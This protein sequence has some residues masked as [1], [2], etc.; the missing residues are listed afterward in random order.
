VK[1]NNEIEETS[2][3]S[4]VRRA[5]CE[6]PDAEKIINKDG[7]YTDQHIFQIVDADPNLDRSMQFAE[8]WIKH[9]ASTIRI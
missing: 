3:V 1:K 8:M 6:H 7:G 4:N 9:C 5:A 2:N